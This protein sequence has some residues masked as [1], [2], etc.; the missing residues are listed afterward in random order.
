MTLFR[1]NGT[2]ELVRSHDRPS[3]LDQ[4]PHAA[5]SLL[6]ARHPDG[7]IC[8][9]CGLLLATRPESYRTSNLTEAE[10]LA[11][12]CA[13]CRQEQ[14]A[15]VCLAEVR[16]QNLAAARAARRPARLHMR[17]WMRDS[18][19]ESLPDA[20]LQH[21]KI[22]PASVLWV[23]NGRAG[24]PGRPRLL[25]PLSAEVRTRRQRDYQRTYRL[26]RKEIAPA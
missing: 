10:R 24:R 1:G 15:I 25:V 5:I 2:P 8:V 16:A 18:S 19:R 3:E 13:E 21:N 9:R 11:Y 20:D 12:V 22:S 17:D 23:C 26:R 7:L 14:A 4:E 6:R